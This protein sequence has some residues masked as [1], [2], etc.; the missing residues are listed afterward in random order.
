MIRV[1]I[2]VADP[3][4]LHAAVTAGADRLELCSSL[5]VGGLTPSF[6]LM[7]L[8]ADAETPARALIRPRSGP[9]TFDASDAEVMARDVEG[10]RACG[11]SGVVLG[12]SRP[13]GALDVDLLARLSDRCGPLKRTLHRAFDLAPDPFE[14]LERAVDLGFDRILT[15]GG[16]PSALEGAALLRQL[17]EAAGERIAIMVCGG[18]RPETLHALLAAS[19][20][21][22]VHAS[23][24]AQAPSRSCERE[25]RFGFGPPPREAD[26]QTLARLMAAARARS[27]RPL[28]PTG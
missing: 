7:R 5:D 3:R 27:R 23:C 13:D 15:S 2:C 21:S 12:A 16:A 8:A 17:V 19:G 9:F 4:S 18:V 22:E 14:S 24:R 6:G 11:L 10:A 28:P 20:A 26:P 25:D 1:E